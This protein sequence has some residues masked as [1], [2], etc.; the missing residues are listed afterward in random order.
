MSTRQDVKGVS[1][2]RH[3]GQ[4]GKMLKRVQHDNSNSPTEMKN[5]GAKK[6]LKQLSVT[7]KQKFNKT[8]RTTMS[9]NVEML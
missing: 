6:V 3:S 8:T 1:L 4:D 9:A 7:Q 2:L 5:V